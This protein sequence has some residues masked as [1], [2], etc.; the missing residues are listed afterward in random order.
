MT[1]T[2]DFTATTFVVDNHKTLL[3]L[4]RKLNMW[5]PP[6]GHID[7]N[8]LPHDAACRE[9]REETGF[10]VALHSTSHPLGHVQILP[11]PHCIL[12]EDIS[13]DHQHIDL[14]YFGR[15]VGGAL[16]PSI[17][18]SAGVR[19]LDWNQLDSPDIAEDICVLGRAAIDFF[20]QK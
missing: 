16:N 6:G 14:I 11:Q 12:L 4:H 1:I 17:R 3:L 13:T 20:A 18:E 7:P 19:W 8:E 5:L 15:V 9:V 10:E 2:R